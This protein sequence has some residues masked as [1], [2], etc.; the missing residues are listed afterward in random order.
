M[1]DIF[2]QCTD[3][4][5]TATEQTVYFMIL[6][7]I[8][9]RKNDGIS[10]RIIPVILMVTLITLLNQVSL[11]SYLSTYIVIV[12]ISFVSVLF[13]KIK[14]LNA[15]FMSMLFCLTL[16]IIDLFI[17]T[18]IEVSVD[19]GI[20]HEVNQ[21]GWARLFF[22]LTAKAALVTLF[23]AFRKIYHLLRG[24]HIYKRYK[25]ILIV[26]CAF[27]YL[28]IIYL[29]NVIHYGTV[30]Q[31]KLSGVIEWLIVLAFFIVM[32]LTFINLTDKQERENE[33]KTLKAINAIYYKDY[34]TLS[35][36]YLVNSKNYHD[37]NNHLIAIRDLV[38]N[39]KYA[40]AQTYINE[41]YRPLYRLTQNTWTGVT[42]VDA[43]I[44]DKHNKAADFQ[45]KMEVNAEYITKTEIQISDMCAIISNLLD[46]AIEASI[47]EPPHA[48]KTI[49][50]TIRVIH[51]MVI[52]KA[53]NRSERNPMLANPKLQTGKADRTNHGW[54]LKSVRY[55][56]RKYDGNMEFRY[57]DRMFSVVVMLPTGDEPQTI[58]P[59][60]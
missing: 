4:L 19:S 32:V 48:E 36:A 60:G 18:L 40:E 9:G 53:E 12:L 47:N 24:K 8:Y 15:F 25:V 50:F 51:S 26:M 21:Y 33:A 30:Y 5:V 52:I 28:Y 38:E 58:P 22:I 49:R 35:N 17:I 29:T 31:L 27:T 7:M 42:A 14:I 46:N 3:I 20:V 37:F 13:F 41:I 11:F 43:I 6:H 1:M 54:G 34:E 57:Q 56:V 2:F 39:G 55:A 45:I 10:H 59:N 44:S 23:L 16:Y